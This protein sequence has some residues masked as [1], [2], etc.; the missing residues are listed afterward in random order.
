MKIIDGRSIAEEILDEV[1]KEVEVIEGRPYYATYFAKTTKVKKASKGRRPGLAIILI[2]EREDSTIYVGLKE[3]KAKEVGIDTHLY[4]CDSSTEEKEIFEVIE[5]LNRDEQIDAILVQLPLPEKF[6]TNKIIEKIDPKKDV[7]RFHPDNLKILQSTCKH[8]HVMPP[9]FSVI[10]KV[11]EQVDY[12][13]KGKEVC[14]IANSDVFG[15]NLTKVLECREASVVMATPEEEDLAKKTVKADVLISAVGQ[16]EFIKDYMIKEGAVVIDVGITKENGKVYGDVDFEN[17]IEKVSYI[18]PVPGGVGP[19]TVA[20][21]LKNVVALRA[22]DL[23]G[24][25]AD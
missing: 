1:K 20:M 21:L 8:G 5:H 11:L 23:H 4:K 25:D 2:G 7:D 19:I 24:Q 13:L 15:K 6:D 18:T 9:V 22:A 14:I 17:V 12:N 16:P 10:L 3:K